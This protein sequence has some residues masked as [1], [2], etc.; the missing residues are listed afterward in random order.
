VTAEGVPPVKSEGLSS[1]AGQGTPPVK[2]RLVLEKVLAVDNQYE[3]RIYPRLKTKVDIRYAIYH[4]DKDNPQKFRTNEIQ[5]ASVTKDISAGGV[6]FISGY[7][8]PIGTI[9]HMTIQIPQ[10]QTG[11]HCLAKICRVEDDTFSAMFNLVAYF[12]DISSSDRAR[13]EEFIDR[14]IKNT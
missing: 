2:E 8:L 9:V 1:E 11:I 14:Q 10:P 13:L 4:Q 3:S 5:H 6:R 12:L 7:A